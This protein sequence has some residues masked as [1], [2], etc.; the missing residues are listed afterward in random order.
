MERWIDHGSEDSDPN[1]GSLAQM[2]RVEEM[3][4]GGESK[5]NRREGRLCVL[6]GL[7]LFEFYGLFSQDKEAEKKARILH[8]RCVEVSASFFFFLKPLIN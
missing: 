2:F 7:V 5:K 8:F 3:D 1:E 4:N 6:Q